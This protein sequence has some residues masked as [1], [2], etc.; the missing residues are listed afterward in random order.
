M[1]CGLDD[2]YAAGKIAVG[3]QLLQQL[4]VDPAQTVLIGDTLHDYEVAEALGVACVL[5][6]HG[7]Y[8]KQR[9]AQIHQ[10]VVDSLEH[11]EYT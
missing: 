9:L 5:V 6:S 1:I 3:R 11:L 7:H 8:A 2:H 4:K 10:Y